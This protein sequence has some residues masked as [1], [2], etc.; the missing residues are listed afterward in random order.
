LACACSP[1]EGAFPHASLPHAEASLPPTFPT[2][3]SACPRTLAASP[4]FGWTPKGSVCDAPDAPDAPTLAA[5]IAGGDAAA[6]AIAGGDL[7]MS[8]ADG[9]ICKAWY[10]YT[11]SR[12]D[13]K[14]AARE[15]PQRIVKE[16]SPVMFTFLE[17][18]MP[19]GATSWLLATQ[20][21]ARGWS[22]RSNPTP[23]PLTC[24]SSK[25]E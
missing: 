3:L 25:S 8:S 14:G 2:S 22:I 16:N 23:H 20:A 19:Q 11:N 17:G 12:L 5:A 15:G 24:S 10:R 1:I 9:S 6:A 18:G 21:H 7:F 4:G 13:C